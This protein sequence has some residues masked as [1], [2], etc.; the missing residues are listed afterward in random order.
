MER[1]LSKYA[2]SEYIKALLG[3]GLV[4]VTIQSAQTPHDQVTSYFFGGH[5][6]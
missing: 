6:P 4:S 5:F 1:L 3:P 2:G